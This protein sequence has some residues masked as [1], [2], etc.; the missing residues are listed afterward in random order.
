M[1]IPVYPEVS[2][3]F[4]GTVFIY[5][6]RNPPK[7]NNSQSL[8]RA[9][10]MLGTVL[11][12]L[13]ALWEAVKVTVHWI[14]MAGSWIL[15]EWSQ[16]S[17]LSSLCLSF[18]ICVCMH[19]QSPG[20]VGLFHP[21]DCSLPDSFVHGIFPARIVEWVAISSSRG[22]SQPRDRTQVSCI[23]GGFLTLSTLPNR[24]Q[25]EILNPSPQNLLL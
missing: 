1:L 6:H 22:S 2:Q 24:P 20:W 21:M 4:E 16:A 19:A 3:L 10:Y 8:L 7:W 14:L 25:W 9:Y 17:H 23:A 13:R 12:T 15:V 11:S 5:L 18:L